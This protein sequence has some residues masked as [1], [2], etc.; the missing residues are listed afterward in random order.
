MMVRCLFIFF[1]IGVSCK[2]ESIP[3]PEASV[4]M[5]PLNND[6]CSTAVRI[7]D[8]RSQ[9]SF[10]W[11]E[12]IHTDEYELVVRDILTNIDQKKETIRLFTSIILE[13]GKQYSWWVNTKSEQS[14]TITK[15]EVWTFYLEG[16]PKSSNFPYPAKLISPVNNSQVSLVDGK[17]TLRWE[18]YDL[19]NDIESYDLY[20]GTEPDGLSLVAENLASVSVSAT[21]S[22]DQYYYW[23]VA[24]KDEEG[25]VSKSPIGVFRTSP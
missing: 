19:D 8:Q 25:N 17:L 23:R 11:Q 3:D 14:E 24:T 4:L 5:G 15:S 22:P 9:V 2:K 16:Q 7:S 6:N 10:S 1:L 18:T 12:A 21:L 20:L 13:R